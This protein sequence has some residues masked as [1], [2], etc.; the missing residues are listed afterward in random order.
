MKDVPPM[1]TIPP[2]PLRGKASKTEASLHGAAL[3]NALKEASNTVKALNSY[4]GQFRE[5]R[6]SVDGE[7]YTVLAKP[8]SG[9]AAVDTSEAPWQIQKL[10]A[11]IIR[12]FPS[13]IWDGLGN[14]VWAS[15][16]GVLSTAESFFDVPLPDAPTAGA[17]WLE[18]S[19]DDTND[20]HGIITAAVIRIG[21]IP[22]FQ[23]M[24][25]GKVNIP[26]ALYFFDGITDFTID[27]TIAFVFTL[28]R[29]GPPTSTTWD[30]QPK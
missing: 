4:L 12:I 26:L 28:R 5:T 23:Q 30:I 24:E 27:Q 15:Y 25:G 11:R 29:F 3:A 9:G 2:D 6:I 8:T 18:C 17:V 7:S 16:E 14:H 20:Y 1:F 13:A 22:S 19:V 21:N 10:P